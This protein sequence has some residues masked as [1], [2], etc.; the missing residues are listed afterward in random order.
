MMH[1]KRSTG[2]RYP[3]ERWRWLRFSALLVSLVRLMVEL[4]HRH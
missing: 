2:N 3:Q 1:D 4:T